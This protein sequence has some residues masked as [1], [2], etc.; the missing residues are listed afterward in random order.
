MNPAEHLMNRE[1][2]GAGK[3]VPGASWRTCGGPDKKHALGNDAGVSYCRQLRRGGAG[4]AAQ[5]RQD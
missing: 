1:E 5:A 4:M 2:E 3:V